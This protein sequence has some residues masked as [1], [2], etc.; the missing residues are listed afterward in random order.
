ML[1]VDPT[2]C[3]VYVGNIS[4]EV[5]QDDLCAMLASQGNLISMRMY[6]KE[7]YAFAEYCSH[8]E[9]VCAII[10]APTSYHPASNV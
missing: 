1:Q 5:N 8:P 10:G 9:A 2:N 3:N 7:G 6:H 4:P